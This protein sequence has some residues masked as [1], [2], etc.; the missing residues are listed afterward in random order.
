VKPRRKSSITFQGSSKV[1]SPSHARAF[2]AL[3][4]LQS[5]AVW[6]PLPQLCVR[7]L[8]IPTCMAST[9]GAVVPRLNSSNPRV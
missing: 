2:E 8:S 9:L 4:V 5:A 7:G 6:I 1:E 3:R